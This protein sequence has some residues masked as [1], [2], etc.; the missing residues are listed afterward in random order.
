MKKLLFLMIITSRLQAQLDTLATPHND[1][2]QA[3][4]EEAKIDQLNKLSHFYSQYS[5]ESSERF[6]HEALE[7]AD[8]INYLKGIASS[9][10]NLG[11][12]HAIRGD[13]TGGLDYFIRAL[14]I[15]EQLDDVMNVSHT[16]NNISRLFILQK[17]FDKAL[18]YAKKSMD[19]LQQ[20][21]D[22]KTLASAHISM[23]SIYLSKNDHDAAI[24]AFEEARRIF[25][26]KNLKTQEGWALLKVAHV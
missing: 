24:G 23:G 21:D 7:K 4:T 25:A 14:R 22:P 8:K 20:I 26:S 15:R 10:N 19:I 5:L 9:Y 6:A 12:C 18:E 13:Y 11:I 2:E 16:L 17:E 1:L 3:S